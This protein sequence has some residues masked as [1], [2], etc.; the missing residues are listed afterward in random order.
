[1]NPHCDSTQTRTA[2]RHIYAGL[3]TVALS[4]VMFEFLLTR[5]FSVTMWYHFAFI[6]I[7]I[8]MFGMTVG[9]VLVFLFPA[10]FR[11]ERATDHLALSSLLFA[12]MIV[13]SFLT[14]LS[15]PIVLGVSVVSLFALLLTYVVLALPF[16]LSGI[17]VSLA[18][19]RYPL[20][21]SG[22]YAADLIGAALSCLLVVSLLRIVDG[23]TAVLICS[24]LAAAASL[25]FAGG[26]GSLRLKKSAL[27]AVLLLVIFAGINGVSAQRQ[28]PL[29]T[30]QWVKG[31][32]E[33]GL[34]YQK[35]NSFSRVSVPYEFDKPFGQ[36]FSVRYK[37]SESIRQLYLEI[38][39]QAA[40][41]LTA[42]DG[43][44]APL[45]HLMFDVT[46]VVYY[47][48]SQGSVLVVGS[49]GGRDVLSALLFGEKSVLAVEINEEIIDTVNKQYGDFTGHL[50]RLSNVRFVND[51][52]RSYIARSAERFDIEQI[53]LIDTWAATAAGALALT[54]NSLYTV[55]AWEVLLGHLSRQG[56]LSV[57]RWFSESKPLEIQRVLS[58]A[59]AALSRMGV[60]DPRGH[61]LV[62]TNATEQ[63]DPGENKVGTVLVSRDPY[64][65]E[66]LN[67]VEELAKQMEFSILAGPA[68]IFL[69][70]LAEAVHWSDFE[71]T[72]A[73][74]PYDLSAP[75]DDRPFFFN[76][77]RLRD[78]FKSSLAAQLDANANAVMLLY[79]L[80]VVILALG[81]G[82]IVLPLRLATNIEERRQARALTCY[83]VS[84]GLGYMLVEISQMQRLAIFLGHPVYSL[85]IV[86]FTLLL[87]SGIGSSLTRSFI[88]EE[89]G[90]AQMCAL[91]SI[92]AVLFLF[93]LLSPLLINHYRGE[94]TALRLLVAAFVMFPPG[95]VMGMAFPVGMSIANRSNAPLTPWFWG[96]NGAASV[97]ASVL[98]VIIALSFGIG[99]AF[100]AGVICYLFAVG[101]YLC[102][103]RK[104]WV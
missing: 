58:L 81:Y 91:V 75:T 51:E 56:V 36:G 12:L 33:R 94:I 32:L 90:L 98:T 67:K 37:S 102:A 5:I 3:F 10:F 96:V 71:Q 7:S 28:A 16:V 19:T 8:A 2:G 78:L 88:S 22:L 17:C 79:L 100:W 76:M 87:A 42:F 93:G 39:A 40:T 50:D 70:P 24:A 89:S 99:L 72:V 97:V 63:S 104:V 101:S 25:L 52:A 83:F 55:E 9:A 61:V 77:L 53:S 80:L 84:I 69:S 13:I 46:N 85:G 48:R 38:D 43:N 44:F 86:L 47:L 14:H 41:V 45:Q 6:C 54:E 1:M 60:A 18:L 35:W 30:L 74:A 23:P 62:L 103:R 27:A 65:A 92:V 66:D 82:A 31:K 4:T 20:S 11:E 15:V 57:S 95:L 64:S 21:I 29:L 26:C 34:L 49:G 59:E 68:G 73:A